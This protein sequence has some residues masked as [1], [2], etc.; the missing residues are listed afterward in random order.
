MTFRIVIRKVIVFFWIRQEK[1]YLFLCIKTLERYDNKEVGSSDR[2]PDVQRQSHHPEF[3][4][5]RPAARHRLTVGK[6]VIYCK[7]FLISSCLF[8]K[9]LRQHTKMLL[10]TLCKIRG[11]GK[12]CN[13][14]NF[15]DTIRTLL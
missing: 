8:Y 2:A 7:L 9:I 14:R 3:L 1:P 4:A 15:I 6:Q 10:E 11:T 12:T 5:P 13:N